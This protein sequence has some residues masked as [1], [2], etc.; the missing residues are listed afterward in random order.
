MSRYH[1]SFPVYILFEI[2][3]GILI[4]I[5]PSRMV[6]HSMCYGRMSQPGIKSVCPFP[7]GVKQMIFPVFPL[8][9]RTAP[10]IKSGITKNIFCLYLHN[11]IRKGKFIL[12]GKTIL[13][14]FQS[15]VLFICQKIVCRRIFSPVLFHKRRDVSLS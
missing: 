13:T 15:G 6:C 8:N 3:N 9:H 5:R 7:T 4:V 12:S 1:I 14:K 10:M 2:K 11:P